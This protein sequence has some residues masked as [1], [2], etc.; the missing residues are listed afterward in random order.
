MSRVLSRLG[1]I[2]TYVYL[3]YV[4]QL[5]T[6]AFDLS[7]KGRIKYQSPRFSLFK[8]KNRVRSAGET[9]FFMS[10]YVEKRERVRGSIQNKSGK[11][12]K[13]REGDRKKKRKRKR[14]KKEKE[15][16]GKRRRIG[17]K[18]VL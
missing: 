11:R 9:Q 2:R 5:A 8:A 17:K 1:A 10:D 15:R 7:K 4:R 12:I 14:R 18:D 6:G 3:S 13:K 16:G